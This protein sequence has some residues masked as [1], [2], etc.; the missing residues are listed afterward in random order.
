MH[1]QRQGGRLNLHRLDD[2]R[3]CVRTTAKELVKRLGV[4]GGIGLPERRRIGLCEEALRR[5]LA[6]AESARQRDDVIDHGSGGSNRAVGYDAGKPFVAHHRGGDPKS[7]RA[8][9][10]GDPRIDVEMIARQPYA[11]LVEQIAE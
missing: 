9:E 7:Q 10:R 3:R 11:A 8:L 5:D 6:I 2:L 4:V 1:V